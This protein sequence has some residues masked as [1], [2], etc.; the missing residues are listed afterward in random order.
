MIGDAAQHL[1]QPAFRIDAVEACRSQQGVDG[2]RAL[3]IAV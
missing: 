2:S 1:E 3:T